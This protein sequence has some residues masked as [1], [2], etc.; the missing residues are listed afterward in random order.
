MNPWQE[1]A[2]DPTI[3]LVVAD[4]PGDLLGFCDHET[5]T[6]WL[7]KGMRQRQRNAVLQHE[8]L[9]LERGLVFLHWE[10]EEERAVEEATARALIA[11]G[12]LCDALLWTRDTHELAEELRVPVSLLQ[13]RADTMKH[14]AER[15]A[16]ERV[17]A[18][19]CDYA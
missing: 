9:H 1:L 17:M 10:A 6:I 18:T 8:R 5:R 13:V 11:I 4:L 15:A 16:V 19:A 2:N 3:T 12:D 7:R 14:P